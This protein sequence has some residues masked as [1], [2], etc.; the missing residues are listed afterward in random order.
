MIVFG[1]YVVQWVR[2]QVG[3]SIGDTATAIGYERNGILAAGVTFEMH[4]VNNIFVCLAAEAS[5]TRDFWKIAVDYAFKQLGCSRITALIAATNHKSIKLAE[6]GGFVEE[7]RM[8]GASKD[9]SDLIVYALWKS[10][11][12]ILNWGTT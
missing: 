6:N 1:K 7:A 3:V 8:K 4:T 9:G 5:P 2:D 11:C 12:R 10:D